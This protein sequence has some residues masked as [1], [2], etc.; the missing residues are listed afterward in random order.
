MCKEAYHTSTYKKCTQ[1]LIYDISRHFTHNFVPGKTPSSK[2][3]RYVCHN[4][5][6]DV[7]LCNCCKNHCENILQL[8]IIKI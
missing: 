7:M 8:C 5:C 3:F 1:S 6:C 2:T 4:N